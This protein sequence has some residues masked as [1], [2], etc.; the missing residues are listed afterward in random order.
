MM[1][2]KTI[3]NECDVAAQTV[4]WGVN[5]A[6]IGFCFNFQWD[7]PLIV[8]TIV[9]V[10]S[11]SIE[12][13]YTSLWRQPIIIALSLFILSGLVSII[14]S[15]DIERSW[16]MSRIFLPAILIFILI[17]QHFNWRALQN[18]CIV[19]TILTI[20]LS[21]ALI[22]IALSNWMQTPTDWIK[23]LGSP[24]LVVPND[25]TL[26]S[27]LMPFSLALLLHR[28]KLIIH[29][30]AALSI[31]L[32][33]MSMVLL[34][35]R[36]ALISEIV[37]IIWMLFFLKPRYVLFFSFGIVCPLLMVDWLMG[38]PLIAKH[39]FLADTRLRV[40]LAAWHMFLD[41]PLWG[42]GPRTF[43]LFYQDYLPTTEALAW[44]PMPIDNRLMP[45]AH[46]LYLELLAE[47]GIVGFVTFIYLLYA[48]FSTLLHIVNIEQG[49]IRT[50]A[51]CVLAS[52][53]SY[54]AAA[55]L[56]SSFLRQWIVI[57]FFILSA[58]TCLLSQHKSTRM[59][60]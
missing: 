52:L 25:V 47:Q 58:I 60:F 36:A 41:S 29:I 2:L 1:D 8:L 10:I 53:C 14:V 50:F 51:I 20:G 39:G 12:A 43:L 23:S 24:M 44:L 21:M 11:A 5:L 49:I 9:G 16:R 35:S 3:Q 42:H 45:W 48:L 33:L 54:C 30:L 27:T 37:V 28:N 13:K 26:F 40:W 59:N 19:F 7:I 46:N 32:G 34:K 55:I 57:M 22:W 56:E 4:C 17:A 6:I 38:F 15:D 18:L 31:I